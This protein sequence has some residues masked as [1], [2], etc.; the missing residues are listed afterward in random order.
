MT[1][2]RDGFTLIDA[3]LGVAILT[4]AASGL[5][6]LLRQTMSSTDAMIDRD[7]QVRAAGMAI[8]SVVVRQTAWLDQHLGAS[9]YQAWTLHVERRTAALYRITLADTA[10]DVPWIETTIYTRAE[11]D[12]ADASH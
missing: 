12:S 3:I 8:A 1:R 6:A 2:R 7:R 4:L 11:R 10:T 5:I 9:R